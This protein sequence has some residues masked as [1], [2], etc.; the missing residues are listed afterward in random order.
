MIV[1]H[2]VQE[3]GIAPLCGERVWCIDSVMAEYYGSRIE[4]LEIVG[5]EIRVLL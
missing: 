4:V 2:A 5:D 3:D 1:G